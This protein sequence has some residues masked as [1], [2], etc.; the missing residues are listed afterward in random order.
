MNQQ[1]AFNVS[2]YNY[3]A[4][5]Q[6]NSDSVNKGNRLVT[7]RTYTQSGRVI[8]MQEESFAM[9][10]AYPGT[11]IGLGNVHEVGSTIIGDV[12]GYDQKK[13]DAIRNESVKNGFSLDY[14][15]GS[16]YWPGASVK[17]AL[18]SAFEMKLEQT[19]GKRYYVQ[20]L[21]EQGL[22]IELP[23]EKYNQLMME[24][25]GSGLG[26]KKRSGDQFKRIKG[27]DTFLDALVVKPN[28][29][30]KVLGTDYI[31]SHKLTKADL[32][33]MDEPNPIKILKILPNV[34]L[35]FRFRLSDSEVVK[36]LTHEK[37]LELF[38]AIF[39]KMGIGAKTNTGYGIVHSLENSVPDKWYELDSN[40]QNE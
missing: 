34:T 31:T 26:A 30:Q 19:D 25:F 37:K 6:N 40:C 8:A 33:G 23:T 1:Y 11:V 13:R 7:D 3:L 9:V 35:L 18:R 32:I 28:K 17:G 20:E 29:N 10:T 12:Y 21:L 16:P 39:L 24:I 4:D 38:E 2:Y 5:P 15:T 14:V 36:E 27:K 22:E